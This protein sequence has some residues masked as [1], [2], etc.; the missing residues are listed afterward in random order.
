[1]TSTSAT[2]GNYRFT[3]LNTNFT[4]NI[5]VE[6]RSTGEYL[7]F[8]SL[9]QTLFVN[10]GRNLGGAK[11]EFD[12]K[13]L[14]LDTMSRL[15]VTNG[16][17]TLASGLN[18]G[19][20]MKS[21]RFFVDASCT[22]DVNWPIT[23]H[24]R[25]WKEGTG[26]LVLGGDVRFDSADGEPE[27]TS[28]LFRVVSGTVKVA[29]HNAMDGLATT[30]DNGT[31]LVLA[32]NPE[33]A[34][35]TKYGILNAKTETPFVLNTGL[36]KL[37]LTVDTS[38]YPTVEQM[39]LTLGL[40]TVTNTPATVSAVRDMLPILKPYSDVRQR[41]VERENAGEGTVTFALELKHVGFK[42]VVR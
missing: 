28:N 40:V 1:M 36:S 27:A 42:I 14:M 34:N 33:D 26:T 13:A 18:R 25:M 24:G 16:T 17:V 39:P 6:Q 37:P 10:D 32:I 11:D 4:G 29:A 19:I 9:F 23:M 7:N 35:L 8:D 22:L 5:A 12:A 41:I 15:S 3:G 2:K 20:Y 21:G 38:A 30:F 31:S